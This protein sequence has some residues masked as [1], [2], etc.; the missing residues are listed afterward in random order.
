MANGSNFINTDT[1]E[2]LKGRIGEYTIKLAKTEFIIT[3]TLLGFDVAFLANEKNNYVTNYYIDFASIDGS[4]QRYASIHELS[5]KNNQKVPIETKN[6]LKSAYKNYKK[7]TQKSERS[8]Q[9][10]D[11]ASR[12]REQIKEDLKMNLQK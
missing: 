8:N 5:F 6:I 2:K 7:M 3:G 4:M 12:L 11:E 1:I 10:R 9:L